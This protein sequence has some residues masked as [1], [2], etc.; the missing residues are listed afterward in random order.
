MQIQPCEARSLCQ[1]STAGQCCMAAAYTALHRG[2]AISSST[3]AAACV[4]CIIRLPAMAMCPYAL[5]YCGYLVC[6]DMQPTP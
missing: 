6:T 5:K 2:H 4:L 1:H 3:L